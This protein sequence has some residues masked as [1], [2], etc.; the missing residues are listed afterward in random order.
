MKRIISLLLIGVMLVLTFTACNNEPAET[1]DAPEVELVQVVK[2]KTD[3]KMNEKLTNDHLELVEVNAANLPENVCKKVEDVVSKYAASNLYA[4]DCLNASQ[5][6][7][8]AVE[9]DSGAVLKQAIATTSKGFV[10]VGDYIRPNTGKDVHKYLQQLI[11]SNPGGS[12]Y[13]SDGEYVIS[14]SLITS[15]EGPKSTTFFFSDNA[16][17]KASDDWKN[18]VNGANE[19]NA[20]I[21]LGQL[22]SDGT[23]INDSGNNGSYF[24]VFGGTFDGNNKAQGICIASSRESVIY[25]CLIKNATIGIDVLWGA[26]GGPS[27][28]DVENVEIVGNGLKGSV[29]IQIGR[30]QWATDNTFTNIKIY[31]METGVYANGGGN[32][33]RNV[34]VYFSEYYENYEDTKGYEIST[35]FLYDCYVENASVA[36]NLRDGGGYILDGLAAGWTYAAK[37]QT[38][39]YCYG[40]LN[41]HISHCRVDFYDGSTYNLFMNSTSGSGS[42]D[43]PILNTEYEK[44]ANYERFLTSNGIIDLSK[45]D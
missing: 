23:H 9:V 3:V 2:L 41:A 11:D 14:Q 28:A 22:R 43:M 12:L 38:A 20:L 39:F 26:N 42:I 10:V 6:L 13:F 15:S 8:K 16:V 24:G 4:G 27:D 45:I 17:L 5:L 35:N 33:F 25:G 1:P 37:F 36:Y 7:D 30:I 21:C 40:G 29:G 18:T 31:D 34:D 32:A 19:N 44:E